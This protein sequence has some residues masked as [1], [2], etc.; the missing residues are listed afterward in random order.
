MPLA[1]VCTR[2]HALLAEPADLAR[3]GGPGP[4]VACGAPA[5]LEDLPLPEAP[6]PVRLPPGYEALRRLEG[7]TTAALYRARRPGSKAAV[8]MKVGLA[9]RDARKADHAR[10]RREAGLLASFR[11]PS[12][13]HLL[14][15]GEHAGLPFL[16]TEW[17]PGGS[18]ADRLGGE[19]LPP[20][21]AVGWLEAVSRAVHHAHLRR[22]V[23]LDL[24]PTNVLFSRR[25]APKLIDFGLARRLGGPGGEVRA[26]E[27]GGDPRYMAPEQAGG[28]EGPVGPAA[29]V[30]GLGAVLYHALTGRL[31]FHG[32][33]FRQ[34]LRRARV[35]VPRPSALRPELPP[36]LDEVC[37]R[38][39]RREPGRR[40][41]T[42]GALAGALREV[43]RGW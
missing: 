36:A 2:G 1:V 28:E 25:G 24:R 14:D 13:V 32:L 41:P 34:R 12:I 16:V 42:A 18:L 3:P 29:D 26:G 43:L 31:P 17:L 7:A 38:C 9:G 22:V 35:R 4:C 11:H 8:A 30:H 19:P 20:R 21:T 27:V 10:L 37:R 5:A 39:L 40:F 6:G 33:C 23:H 15:A